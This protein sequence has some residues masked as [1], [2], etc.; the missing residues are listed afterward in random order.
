MKI[1]IVSQYFWPE[2]FRINDLAKELKNRGHEITVLTG[3]PNY[4]AGNWFEGY[5]PASCGHQKWHGIEVIRVPMLRR[6]SGRGWQLALNYLSFTVAASLL[7][8][9]WC[10]GCFDIVF[11]YEPSPFTVGIPAAVMRRVKGAPMMFWVQDLWPESLIAAGAVRSRL[12]LRLVAHMVRWI[13]ARCDRV[14]VQS[15][16]FYG[17]A[18]AA[19]ADAKCI[20]YFPNWAESFYRPVTLA[21]DAPERTDL[22]THGFKIVFAGN[23]GEAQSLQTILA[24]AER[25]RDR[26]DICWIMIGDG[27]R[28]S[29]MQEEARQRG[30]EQIHFPGS[31]ASERMPLFFSQAEALL[32]TLKADETFARV[33]PSKVQSYMACGRPVVAA[34]DG[35]GRRII[36]LANAGVTAAAEDAQG[37]AN[38]VLRLYNMEP[39]E[40][41][42][43]G[44]AGQAYYETHFRRDLLVD[45]LEHWMQ[46]LAEEGR[47]VS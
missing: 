20:R 24:A 4:P 16:A 38:A 41:K 30:L 2:N 5:G 44:S 39:K 42:A 17:P 23:L 28:R 35:E 37:L 26:P 9:F 27:R 31:F 46:N 43:M 45:Q 12:V 14:L 25:L 8:P 15:E 36:E 40:R 11:A 18:E 3:I 22:P 32:V 47:C 1:L 21:A 33:V 10:R 19:G 7:G 29:W 34:L 6:M 13:Y